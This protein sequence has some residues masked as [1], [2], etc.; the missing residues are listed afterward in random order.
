MASYALVPA[1][2]SHAL[3]RRLDES[4]F[5]TR[6]ARISTTVLAGHFLC[7]FVINLTGVI[8]PGALK[9]LHFTR[10]QA[11]LLATALFAGM[12]V[13]GA[14][15]GTISDRLGRRV[16][17]ACCVLLFA[18]FSLAAAFATS[19]GAL[20]TFR[21]AQGIGLGAEIAVVL[22]YIAELVPS[23]HRG[24]LVA[25][26]TANRAWAR[27]HGITLIDGTLGA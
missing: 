2:S 23:R 12:L 15:A 22:P 14:A 21:A 3:L 10:G 26:S 9:D 27:K 11:G 13:G 18:L 19:Y 20:V 6:H 5:T 24:P 16:P 4:A 8:V 25:T 1:V 7:G 17:L